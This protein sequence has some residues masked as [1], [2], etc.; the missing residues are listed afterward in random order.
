[1]ERADM[2]LTDAES[3]GLADKVV[4]SGNGNTV[5]YINNLV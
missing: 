2:D 1:M 5:L 3:D 4:A